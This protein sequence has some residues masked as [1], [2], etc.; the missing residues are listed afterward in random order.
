MKTQQTKNER[1]LTEARQTATRLAKRRRDRTI[2]INDVRK[3]VPVP[4]G[5]N[6]SILGAVFTPSEWKVVGTTP[7]DLP[8]AR[9]RQ[10]RQFA[11]RTATRRQ[12]AAA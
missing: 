11:L 10:I 3:A 2:T 6:A 4:R 5:V 9:G 7:S 12:G 8:S 1:Y